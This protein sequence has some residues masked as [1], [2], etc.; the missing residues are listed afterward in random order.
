MQRSIFHGHGKEQREHPA[1]EGAALGMAPDGEALERLVR[2]NEAFILRAAS[3]VTGRYITKEDDEWSVALEAFVEAARDYDP[4]KGSLQGFA[5]VVIRRRLTDQFRRD[6]ARSA[7]LSVD[8][9]VFSSDP[10]EEEEGLSLRL[11][12]A[13]KTAREEPYNLKEEIEAAN[14]EF[15]RFGF[16]FFDLASCSPK[17]GKTKESC[18]RAVNALLETPL[19][20]ETL[21]RTGQLPV[22][23]LEERSGVPRKILERHRKYL[24]AAVIL[25][26]GDYPVPPAFYRR[27]YY[28][29][30][31]PVLRDGFGECVYLFRIKALSGLVSVWLYKAQ[32]Y[33][34]YLR[35]GGVGFYVGYPAAV[36]SVPRPFPSPFLAILPSFHIRLLLLKL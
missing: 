16:S 36:K 13:Q 3:T 25:L 34:R 15:A 22:R 1:K 27:N 19:L 28:R 8:P 20:R 26:A 7:E 29:L 32:L 5:Q 23:A 4:E 10:S 31:E 2:E 35:S 14:Q 24:V 12:V 21:L 30:Y 33:F 6:R 17:A 18:A 11:A 9:S